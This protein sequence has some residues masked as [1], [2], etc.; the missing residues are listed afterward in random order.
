MTISAEEPTTPEK[1]EADIS[2]Y[3]AD[4]PKPKTRKKA[5]EKTEEPKPEPV[6]QAPARKP[7][8]VVGGGE[9]DPVLFSR[10]V[11]VERAKTRK[12]LTVHHL[13]RRLEELGYVEARA[14]LDGQWGRLTG[15]SV[16]AWQKDNGHPE[17]DLTAE[18]FSAIFE[19]DINVIVVIDM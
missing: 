5:A 19:D 7:Y 14:D 13:Q 8:A 3:P 18:Q 9:T 11:P 15:R 10:A 12:S 17:G 4:E 1:G 6:K 16:A 2:M